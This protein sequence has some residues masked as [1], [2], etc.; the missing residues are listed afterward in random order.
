MADVAKPSPPRVMPIAMLKCVA[1]LTLNSGPAPSATR[2]LLKNVTG[3]GMRRCA[4]K[5]P[6][7]LFNE[8]YA[9]D[10][11]MKIMNNFRVL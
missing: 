6:S 9:L 8:I 1:I 3:L 5:S 10:M 7:M 4:V 2:S 11:R